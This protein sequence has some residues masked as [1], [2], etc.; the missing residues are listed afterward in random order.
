VDIISINKINVT[1]IDIDKTKK[2]LSFGIK[3]SFLN[4]WV[5]LEKKIKKENKKIVVKT[6]SINEFGIF[7]K[8]NKYITGLIHNNNILLKSLN[9]KNLQKKYKKN[10]NLITNIISINTKKEKIYLSIKNIVQEKFNTFINKIKKEKILKIKEINEKTIKINIKKMIFKFK[11]NINIVK[12]LNNG[13]KKYIKILNYDKK[14]KI[15][16]LKLFTYFEIYVAAKL[17]ELNS[18]KKRDQLCSAS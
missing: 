11:K 3:Q 17:N 7:V 18:K 14:N 16:N 13:N 2:R 9:L 15:I 12:K 4:P 8:I 1:I 6:K 5:I 10:K